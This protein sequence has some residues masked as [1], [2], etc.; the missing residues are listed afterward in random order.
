MS[1]YEQILTSVDASISKI[2]T[3]NMSKDGI[4][5]LKDLRFLRIE[6]SQSV[7]EYLFSGIEKTEE[8][9]TKALA[10]IKESIDPELNMNMY[11]EVKDIYTRILEAIYNSY[12]EGLNGFELNPRKAQAYLSELIAFS[13]SYQKWEMGLDEALKEN[14]DYDK[15]IEHYKAA[16]DMGLAASEF[17]IILAKLDKSRSFLNRTHSVVEENEIQSDITY[18]HLK[19]TYDLMSDAFTGILEYKRMDLFSEE[20]EDFIRVTMNMLKYHEDMQEICKDDPSS[21]F[22]HFLNARKYEIHWYTLTG[23]VG[24]KQAAQQAYDKIIAILTQRASS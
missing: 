9:L 1:F 21:Q 3:G 23:E 4:V 24:K 17:D 13:D 2:T 16:A 8:S 5:I 11:R 20:K 7:A 19:A 22:K 18:Q 15:A 10:I 14:P 6:R 12:S